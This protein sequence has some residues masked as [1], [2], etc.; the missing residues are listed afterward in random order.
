MLKRRGS[1]TQSVPLRKE[2]RCDRHC[3][4]QFAVYTNLNFISMVILFLKIKIAV[5]FLMHNVFLLYMSGHGVTGVYLTLV[6]AIFHH[7]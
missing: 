4:S 1:Y 6:I 7:Y 2:E 5:A 3:T